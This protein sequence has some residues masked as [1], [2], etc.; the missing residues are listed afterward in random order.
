MA[1]TCLISL[2]VLSALFFGQGPRLAAEEVASGNS[3]QLTEE[4]ALRGIIVATASRYGVDPDLVEAVISVESN[5]APLAMSPKGALGLMQLMPGTAARYGVSNPFNAGENVS[6]GVRYLRDLLIRFDNLLHVLAA[7][8]AGENVIR[9]YSGIPPYRE[10]QS[11]IKKVIN[12]YRPGQVL[13]TSASVLAL[14]RQARDLGRVL[15]LAGRFVGRSSERPDSP[16]RQG[17]PGAPR[18]LIEIT[19][20]PLVHLNRLPQ[21][22][23]K[24]RVYNR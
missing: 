8:N 15:H 20:G 14:G 18:P 5:F 24:L 6:G 21:S 2:V 17:S 3:L 13:L 12:R 19:R 23:V 4:G 11:Y 16:T 9:R 22:S 10:T 1:R 7:Y